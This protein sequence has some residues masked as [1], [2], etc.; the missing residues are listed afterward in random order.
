MHSRTLHKTPCIPTFQLSQLLGELIRTFL[1]GGVVVAH[2]LETSEIRH[3]S[4]GMC[5]ST[6]GTW[7]IR[8]LMQHRSEYMSRPPGTN[9]IFAKPFDMKPRSPPDPE[10][11]FFQVAQEGIRWIRPW[12][13]LGATS[14]GSVVGEF[15]GN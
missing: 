12:R 14:L 10:T 3:H 6:I 8:P 4:T 7:E 5:C 15:I 9:E 2:R 1:G 13:A 11:G